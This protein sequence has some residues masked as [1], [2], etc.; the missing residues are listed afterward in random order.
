M[1]LIYLRGGNMANSK[2][3]MSL[4]TPIDDKTSKSNSWDESLLTPVEEEQQYLAPKQEG[5]LSKLP[6][7]IAAGL[8]GLGHGII[9]TPH[10]I[11]QGIEGL[12]DY[13]NT[14]DSYWKDKVN[15]ERLKPSEYIPHQQ[16]YNFAQML[17]Q[18][19]NGTDAD[20][21]L[22]G[23]IAHSP[24][25]AGAAGLMKAGL[26][27][28][29]VTAKGI[30]NKLSS[31]K[32]EA[33]NQANIEYSDLFNQAANQ[34]ITHVMPPKSAIE[35]VGRI[36]SN[37]QK[38]HNQSLNEYILN[39]TL[40]NAHRAQSE[41]GS[42]ER[43]LDSIANKNG[44]TPTQHKTLRAAQKAREDIKSQMFAENALGANPQLGEL[45]KHITNNY[46]KNVIPYTRLQELTETE[47][48]RML[49]KKAVKQLLNDDQ[50][51]IELS[52]RY[53][54]LM[55]HTP[56]AK[57]ISKYAGTTG[58]GIAGYEGLKKLMQ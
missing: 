51:M 46:R 18:E 25:I 48:G 33:L 10:D 38:K 34:G 42:L 45:Y 44:L 30:T 41:L 6:R 52:K 26:K 54:G 29:P 55:M 21:L 56:K 1:L 12:G 13:L 20:N 3:D 19:G 43:H 39:P 28:I 4:L 2:F 36:T 31:H 50:F 9:N 22:Q 24:E 8:A 57:S 49:P 40:E 14:K 23:L 17:G 16:E 53:P 47:Q 7:N 35:N 11:S 37:S 15:P 58:I 5:F 27:A 32:K